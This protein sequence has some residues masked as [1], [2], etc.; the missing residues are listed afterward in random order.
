MKY[1]KG[2]ML[3]LIATLVLTA[4]GVSA[5]LN[6]ATTISLTL[7]IMSNIAYSQQEA[8]D[9]GS[10]NY[11]ILYKTSCFDNVS[12]DGRAVLGRIR[13]MTDPVGVTGWYELPKGEYVT[14]SSIGVG[15]G[16]FRSEYKSEKSF[17]T[18]A[19]Y[20][21]IWFLDGR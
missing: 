10:G 13:Q 18:T 5:A 8:K 12:E 20:S 3:L 21:G 16:V 14:I 19:S 4:T 9:E 6:N 2:T 15:D 11:Q 17:L 1:L 7:P